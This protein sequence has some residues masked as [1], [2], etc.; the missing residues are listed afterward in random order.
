MAKL[1]ARP[2]LSLDYLDQDCG[3]RRC[4][5]TVVPELHYR[6]SS[7]REPNAHSLCKKEVAD[8]LPRRH[9][10]ATASIT[11]VSEHKR[12]P[13][14]LQ[15]PPPP[16]CCPPRPTPPTAQAPPPRLRIIRISSHH[17]VCCYSHC[18]CYPAPSTLSPTCCCCMFASGSQ[19]AVDAASSSTRC[20]RRR[21]KDTVNTVDTQTQK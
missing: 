1:S 13:P 11:L 9:P 21:Y 20:K 3:P 14:A 8:P 12:L 16:R 7:R 18:S 5:C 17:P 6:P 15:T 19:G 4:S 10:T 2:P